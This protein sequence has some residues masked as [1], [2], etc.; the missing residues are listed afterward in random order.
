[1]STATVAVALTVGGLAFGS[2][3]AN[4]ADGTTTN[5]TASPSTPA[6]IQGPIVSGPL[7]DV[8]GVLESLQIGQFQ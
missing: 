8:G 6:L 1:M 5:V 7:I 3:A 4:A 2:T